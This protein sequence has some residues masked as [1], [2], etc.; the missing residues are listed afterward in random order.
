[1]LCPQCGTETPDS[2]WNCV[3]CR[4]NVYWAHQHY[5]ELARIRSQQGLRPT[6]STP[7]F[8]IKSHQR[9]MHDRAGRGGQ[10]ESKVRTIARRAMSGEVA[11]KP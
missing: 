1:M 7:A 11:E 9:E 3:S 4:V 2:E 5:S 10:T 6:A 8:L